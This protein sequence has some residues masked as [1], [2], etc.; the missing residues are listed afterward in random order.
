MRFRSVCFALAIV[1][2]AAATAH[3]AGVCATDNRVVAAC[4]D[5]HGRLRINA[6][7]RMYLWP[8]GTKRLLA[9][10]YA[11][12]EPRADPALPPDLAKAI[13]LDHDVFGDFRVCPFTLERP[14]RMR[15]VCVDSATHLQRRPTPNAAT[16]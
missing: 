14:G 13:D 7:M 5:V 12:D 11:A 16:K 10:H 8:I 1:F 15:I 9:V 6:N 4:Y 2:I 3:A